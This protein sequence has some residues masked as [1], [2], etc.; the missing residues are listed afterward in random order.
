M[1]ALVQTFDR[2]IYTRLVARAAPKVISTEEENER[3]LAIIEPLMAKGDSKRTAE[4]G[5][6]LELLADLVH[7]F[8]E[9]VY[10]IPDSTPAE[11][12]NFLMEENGL[13]QKD[14]ALVL[15]ASSRVSEILSGKRRVSREQ[16]KRLAGRF[17]MSMEA[18]L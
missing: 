12:L 17:H 3:V 6:L 13:K 14:L 4:E 8:E 16:A 7:D 18:F 5:A 2:K 10:P 11:M 1:N 15:G 9:K